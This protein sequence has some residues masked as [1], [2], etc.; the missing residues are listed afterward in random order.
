MLFFYL[1]CLLIT[2][3]N[4][5]MPYFSLNHTL[6]KK[7][8]ALHCLEYLFNHCPITGYLEGFQIF[9]SFTTLLNILAGK[10]LHRF[11]ISSLR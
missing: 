7:I 9:I 4:W 6:W 1:I 3:T 8:L 2:I 5:K 11:K 10:C